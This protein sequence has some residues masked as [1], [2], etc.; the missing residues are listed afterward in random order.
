MK[1]NLLLTRPW[2]PLFAIYYQPCLR[3][4]GWSL[5]LWQMFFVAWKWRM[6]KVGCWSVDDG[7]VGNFEYVH[8]QREKYFSRAELP[9]SRFQVPCLRLLYSWSLVLDSSTIVKISSSFANKLLHDSVRAWIFPSLPL[10]FVQVSMHNVWYP[11]GV[12]FFSSSFAEKI[13]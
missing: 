12:L 2:V 9:S 10:F 3:W 6:K 4:I 1:S 5:N 8:W 11:F 7:S 13:R